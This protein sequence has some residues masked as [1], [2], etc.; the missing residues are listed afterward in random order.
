MARKRL[1]VI[2]LFFLITGITGLYYYLTNQGEFVKWHHS[3]GTL[4]MF[5]EHEVMYFG[6]YKLVFKG[7]G[8]PTIQDIYFIQTDGT[9][10]KTN[11]KPISITPIVD[12][13]EEIGTVIEEDVIDE[14]RKNE[15]IPISGFKLKEEGFNLA[16][17]V[18]LNDKNYN[19]DVHTLVIEYNHL[20]IN[21][22][23]SI[24]FDG[25]FR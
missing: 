18:K 8:N 21:K 15:L 4:E 7:V 5:N 16:L 11:D 17:R 14:D 19:K 12:T 9:H 20:G 2:F 25:F 3:Y 22:Q 10:I 24:G 6:G 23:Q 1:I 13:S